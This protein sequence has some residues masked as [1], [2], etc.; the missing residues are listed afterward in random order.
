MYD[1]PDTIHASWKPLF[2]AQNNRLRKIMKQLNHYHKKEGKIIYPPPESV[3]R[4]F[5]MDLYQIKLVLLGQDP[6]IQ[7]NQAMGLSF[8][9]PSNERIPPS[10]QNI[11]KEISSNYPKHYTFQHGNLTSWF[12]REHIFL[13]NASLTVEAGKSGSHMTLWQKFT[14]NVMRYIADNNPDALFLLFGNFAKSKMN[15]LPPSAIHN[16]VTCVHPSPL[17]AH[18]GFFGSEVFKK[19]N[20]I[21]TNRALS[22]IC[23][24]N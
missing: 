21:Y 15:I 23:W 2:D 7:E 20:N 16:T 12:T 11:F 13:L 22:P 18:N 14:D 8:S 3:F 9:V 5:T 17:S 1:I 24:Q 4:V 6:Y 10:L 19:I